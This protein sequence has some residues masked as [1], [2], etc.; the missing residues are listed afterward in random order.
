MFSMLLKIQFYYILKPIYITL[1]HIAVLLHNVALQAL[2]L[3]WIFL[4]KCY[5]KKKKFSQMYDQP[6]NASHS[7]P[8]C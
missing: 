7:A 3:Q 8:Q 5:L 4:I 6:R 2:I 1:L